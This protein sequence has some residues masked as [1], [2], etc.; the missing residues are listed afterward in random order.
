MEL[1]LIY[2][3]LGLL[4]GIVCAIGDILLDLKGKDN[5]KV[6]NSLLIESNWTKMS[7][8]RIKLSIVLALIG[9]IMYSLGIYSLGRQLSN[10]DE[11]LSELMILFSLVT[12]LAGFFIHSLI[13]IAPIIYK[14]ALKSNDKSLAE[15]TVNE[16]LSAVKI[17]FVVL[18]VFIIL[19]PTVLTSYCI[20]FGLFAVPSWFVLLN[21]L[22]FLLVGITLKK[23]KKDWFYELPSICMP[24]LGLGMFGVVGISN[25]I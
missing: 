8:W 22:V 1:N 24:S 6:G 10:V 3:C 13:C 17:P 5:V 19:A 21:P 7:N 14:A 9:V 23:I 18:Y 20:L 15:H 25:L 4:G 2:S 12:A 16:L 11:N